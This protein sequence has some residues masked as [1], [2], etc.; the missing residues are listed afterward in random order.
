MG[1]S[2]WFRLADVEID[3]DAP[4]VVEKETEIR[5]DPESVWT[6]LT[7]VERWPGWNPDIKSAKLDGDLTKGSQFRWKQGPSSI[8]STVEDLDQPRL[9]SWS[10]KALGAQARHVWRLESTSTGT[11]VSTQESM[12]GLVP[13]LLRGPMRGSLE[14]SLDAWLRELAKTAAIQ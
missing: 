4:V 12:S 2:T 6:I 3:L 7:D 13:S 9:I 10:G 11:R 5:A 1:Q 14:K 8:T